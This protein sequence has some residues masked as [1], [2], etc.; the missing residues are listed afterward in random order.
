MKLR[1]RKNL[2]QI[3]LSGKKGIGKFIFASH[4][5]NYIFSQKEDFN[6]DLKN[7]TINKDNKSFYRK[8][9]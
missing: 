4:F 8:I 6:Y 1:E 2:I 7:F 9:L 5:L 3:L